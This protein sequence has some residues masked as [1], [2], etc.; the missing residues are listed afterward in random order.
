MLAGV[1]VAVGQ[2]RAEP[3]RTGMDEWSTFWA[4]GP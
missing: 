3:G 1:L 4:K 2:N